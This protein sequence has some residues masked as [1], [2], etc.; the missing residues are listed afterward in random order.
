M[1]GEN[2]VNQQCPN[3][4]AEHWVEKWIYVEVCDVCGYRFPDPEPDYDAIAKDQEF[5]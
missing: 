3:C 4:G 5:H 1:T 2:A